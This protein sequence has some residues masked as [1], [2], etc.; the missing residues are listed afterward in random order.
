MIITKQFTTRLS[1]SLDQYF[2][3]ISK[4]EL[5]TPEKELELVI[6]MKKGDENA[7][8]ALIK[9]NL[10]FVVSVAKQYQNQGLPLSDLINEGNM[11]LIRATSKFDETRGFKFISYAVWWIRQAIT[12]AIA[13][14]VRIVHLPLNV[15]S[16]F[17]KISKATKAFE[18]E[19]DRKPSREEISELLEMPLDTITH[20]LKSSGFNSS[21]DAP[22]NNG[23]KEGKKMLDMLPDNSLPAADDSLSKESL[24]QEIQN[25]LTVLSEREAKILVMI[26]GIGR[27]NRATLEDIGQSFHLTRERVRQIKEEALKKLRNSPKA[28]G[29]LIYLE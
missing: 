29:L 8:N 1:K 7:R 23:E 19:Y 25:V 24:A 2:S 11:G 18:D 14:N 26:F 15:I 6:K 27:E 5:L 9:A 3:E 12:Q 28:H 20:V 21:L 4:V 16:D 17:R 10:R 13:D 22:F